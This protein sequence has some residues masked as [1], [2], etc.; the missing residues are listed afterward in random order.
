MH[1]FVNLIQ[2]YSRVEGCD[3]DDIE[4]AVIE[5]ELLI[6]DIDDFSDLSSS[7][8]LNTGIAILETMKFILDKNE[9]RIFEIGNCMYDTLEYKIQDE[10]HEIKDEDIECH[11]II[12]GEIG[13]QLSITRI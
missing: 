5:I 2:E 6:P 13:Y 3:T 4:T 11:P 1:S 9:S 8:A 10:F 7:F 12:L